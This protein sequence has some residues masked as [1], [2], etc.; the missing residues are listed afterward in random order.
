MTQFTKYNPIEQTAP[1]SRN[2]DIRSLHRKTV[3]LIPSFLPRESLSFG[4]GKNNGVVF[5][6]AISRW[7]FDDLWS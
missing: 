7:S 1:N 3:V 5:A 6:H 2:R 4:S